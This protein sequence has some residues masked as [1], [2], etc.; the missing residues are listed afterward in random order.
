MTKAMTA[1]FMTKPLKG[2]KFWK[3]HNDIMN[4]K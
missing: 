1:D 4:I 3:F 2:E